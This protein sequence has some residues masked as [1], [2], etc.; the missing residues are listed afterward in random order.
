VRTGGGASEAARLRARLED[1]PGVRGVDLSDYPQRVRVEWLMDGARTILQDVAREAAGAA[2]SVVVVDLVGPPA[3]EPGDRIRFVT[4]EVGYPEPGRVEIG[5]WL[6]CRDRAYS[7]KAAGKPGRTSELRLSAAAAIQALEA[8]TGNTVSIHLLGVKAL[9]VADHQIAAVL[10]QSPQFLG[11]NLV[12]TAVIGESGH[13]AAVLA[14][15][16]AT[17]RALG[18]LLF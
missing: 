15:L 12:G 14:V 1:L 8:V 4:V 3:A 5:V 18:K 6:Q 7:G 13:R 16:D 9:H 17:N 11:Y 10:L 2:G